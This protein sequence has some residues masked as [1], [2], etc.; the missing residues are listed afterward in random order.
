MAATL[1]PGGKPHTLSDWL[2]LI[3]TSRYRT[4]ISIS[5]YLG[6]RPAALSAA[7]VNAD[8]AALST[9]GA[10]EPLPDLRGDLRGHQL[11]VV[12]VGQVESSMRDC[13]M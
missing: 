1:A 10:S 6:R 9:G 5:S 4:D 7:P 2:L 11:Q 3:S 8:G 12:Q 13:A